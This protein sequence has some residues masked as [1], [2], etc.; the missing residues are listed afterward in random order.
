M[1][2]FRSFTNLLEIQ[3]MKRINTLASTI[4]IMSCFAGNV[5]A[6]EFEFSAPDINAKLSKMVEEKMESLTTTLQTGES[7]YMVLQLENE[8]ENSP[9]KVSNLRG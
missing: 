6:D 5:A 8:L 3:T 1:D 9:R 7:P 2:E 4:L